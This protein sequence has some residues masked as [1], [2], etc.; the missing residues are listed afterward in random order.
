MAISDEVRRKFIESYKVGGIEVLTDS[1][2]SKID[3]VHKTIVYD[4]WKLV[5]TRHSLKSADDHIVFRETSDGMEEAFVKDLRIGDRIYTKDG[6][7]TVCD[8]YNTGE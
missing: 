8:V 7:D 2:W 6:L 3:S 5:T 4:I 1:G